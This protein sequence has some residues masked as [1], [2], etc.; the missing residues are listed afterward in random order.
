MKNLLILCAVVLCALGW[1][2]QV[3]ISSF[4]DVDDKEV[5]LVDVAITQEQPLDIAALS[6]NLGVEFVDLDA[7][8]GDLP[9]SMEVK[10]A[11][12][13]IYTSGD[14][15][16]ARLKV[17]QDN[18]EEVLNVRAG[19][20]L[21]QYHVEKVDVNSILLSTEDKNTKAVQLKMFKPQTVSIKTTETNGE[22]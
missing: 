13:A 14:V 4:P 17:S 11:L 5:T 10:L 16:V 3:V 8:K 21:Y 20:A 18:R 9:K 12:N 22:V 15:A 1:V 7:K 19:D 2:A 6:K